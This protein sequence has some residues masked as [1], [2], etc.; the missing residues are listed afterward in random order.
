MPLIWKKHLSIG[1]AVLDHE[2]KS[3]IGM[4]NSIEYAIR[5]NDNP[6]LFK[7][8]KLFKGIVHAH[9]ANE[10]RI[11]QAVNFDFERH[12]QGHQYLLK[13]LDATLDELESKVA[14]PDDTWCKYAMGNYPE[15]L[16]DWHIKHITGEDMEMKLV[17]QRYHIDFRI[18]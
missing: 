16:R 17:L 7:E 5:K 6:A 14:M 11:A 15:L 10:A 9:F 18:A 8:I 1:N 3:M 2:H 13:E 4:I 12:D